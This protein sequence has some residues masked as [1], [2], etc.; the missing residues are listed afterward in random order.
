MK[1]ADLPYPRT[2]GRELGEVVARAIAF[3]AEDRYPKPAALKLAL[4]T[5]V[6]PW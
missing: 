3:Q 2:A 1:G 5:S 4:L 6:S